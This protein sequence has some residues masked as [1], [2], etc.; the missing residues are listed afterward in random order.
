VADAV[1]N[2][3]EPIQKRYAE[4]SQDKAYLDKVLADGAEAAQHRADRIMSKVY[5]KVGFNVA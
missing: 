3:L 2:V 4:V 1:V 5:R